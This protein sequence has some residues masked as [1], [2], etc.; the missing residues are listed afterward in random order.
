MPAEEADIGPSERTEPRAC[1]NTA[2]PIDDDLFARLLAEWRATVDAITALIVVAGED[3]TVLRCNRA[4]AEQLGR[5]F[6]AIISHSLAEVLGD[7]L[8]FPKD[9][10]DARNATAGVPYTVAAGTRWYDVRS[11]PFIGGKGTMHG[12]VYVL[13]DVTDRVFAERMLARHRESL[14]ALAVRLANVEEHARESVARDLHDG[15]GTTLALAKLKLDTLCLDEPAVVARNADVQV[16]CEQV[17]QAI[18]YTRKL[19]VEL[20]SPFL[21]ELGLTPALRELAERLSGEHHLNIRVTKEE[22]VPRLTGELMRT[23]YQS[24]RELLINVIKHAE[25]SNVT[26]HLARSGAWLSITVADDGVGFPAEQSSDDFP[27]EGKY[28]LFSLQQRML[29]LGGRLTAASTG[30]TGASV[31]L[32]VPL[33]GDNR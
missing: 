31:I 7:W 11:D 3:N 25:A 1:P 26:V 27:S 14:R 5:P 22:D 4:L 30:T 8:G 17:A 9:C 29:A 10:W 20:W 15:L 2:V 28:G 19:T 6:Q 24:V 32:T 13:T 23:L 16:A 12:H 21:H 33:G 18:H